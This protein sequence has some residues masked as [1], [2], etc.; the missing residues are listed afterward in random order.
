MCGKLQKAVY[1]GRNAAQNWESQY[2]SSFLRLGFTQGKSTP[3]V[4]YHK[5]REI[6]AVEHGDDFTSLADDDQLKWLHEQLTKEY[7]LK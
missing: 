5:Q 1:G 7:E 3:C 4:F 2:E 6:R